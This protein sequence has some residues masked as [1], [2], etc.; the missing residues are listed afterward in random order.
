MADLTALK[1]ELKEAQFQLYFAKQ[2]TWGNPNAGMVAY[3]NQLAKCHQL[4]RQI[5]RAE[6]GG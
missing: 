4:Q 2:V 1:A 6:E 3:G 5:Q